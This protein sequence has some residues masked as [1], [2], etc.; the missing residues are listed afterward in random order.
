[1]KILKCFNCNEELILLYDAID[2][3]FIKPCDCLTFEIEDLSDKV[4]DL[5]KQIFILED[6][7][8]KYE[9]L[10]K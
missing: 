5:E 1:M 6:Y 7:K 3:L 2:E 10:E 8:W 9:E 4:R